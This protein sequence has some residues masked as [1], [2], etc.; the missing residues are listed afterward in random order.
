MAPQSSTMLLLQRNRELQLRI[1]EQRRSVEQQIRD[2]ST[3]LHSVLCDSDSSSLT[4][5]VARKPRAKKR[6]RSPPNETRSPMTE[7]EDEPQQQTIQDMVD[8]LVR[9]GGNSPDSDERHFE[10]AEAGDDDMDS[11]RMTRNAVAWY[12]DG[13]YSDAWA[14]E[15][16]RY[17]YNDDFRFQKRCLQQC[18]CPSFSPPPPTTRIHDT[19]S[20]N[21]VGVGSTNICTVCGAFQRNVDAEQWRHCQMLFPSPFDRRPFSA[22]SDKV[23]MQLVQRY[24]NEAQFR[25]GTFPISIPMSPLCIGAGNTVLYPAPLTEEELGIVQTIWETVARTVS[26]IT[27]GSILGASALQPSD[28]GEMEEDGGEGG[29]YGTVSAMACAQR[30]VTLS[31]STAAF[32]ATENYY[33]HRATMP[34]PPEQE[35]QAPTSSKS[36]ASVGVFCSGYKHW[37][38]VSRH[39]QKMC[40]TVRSPF[41]CAAQFHSI[42]RQDFI[43]TDAQQPLMGILLQLVQACFGS[44]T[45][46]S[47][48]QENGL[49]NTAPSTRT[50]HWISWVAKYVQSRVARLSLN[51]RVKALQG[52]KNTLAMDEQDTWL[53]LDIGSC[54]VLIND[55]IAALHVAAGRQ[56]QRLTS[57]PFLMYEQAIRCLYE[58]HRENTTDVFYCPKRMLKSNDNESMIRDMRDKEC[59][60]LTL[61]EMLFQ[62]CLRGRCAVVGKNGGG[63]EPRQH[64]LPGRFHIL[65]LVHVLCRLDPQSLDFPVSRKHLTKLSRWCERCPAELLRWTQQHQAEWAE[66][67]SV[68]LARYFGTETHPDGIARFQWLVTTHHTST[69]KQKEWWSIANAIAVGVLQ[70]ASQAPLIGRLWSFV[71]G[72]MPSPSSGPV[73]S[74][75]VKYPKL[76]IGLSMALQQ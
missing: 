43:A 15:Q 61:V 13:R 75:R 3:I 44:T 35:Q 10:R 45:A 72:G 22:R 26:V 67:S 59:F 17:V 6:A 4:P 31:E 18:T 40:G 74:V 34:R 63:Q 5:S 62:H 28:G 16:H 58:L 24:T 60:Y 14:D 47:S 21:T 49:K 37:I 41:A 53:G 69:T 27:A 46:T 8:R 12:G 51:P 20:N 54:C 33:L 50:Q 36:G 32:S 71:K 57:F 52:Q 11:T 19:T 55:A 66:P 30:A 48:V 64:H 76:N 39:L 25:V 73:A 9:T 1:E 29:R 38:R 70:D 65:L 42:L 68:L 23:L 7:Q 2:L 56:K